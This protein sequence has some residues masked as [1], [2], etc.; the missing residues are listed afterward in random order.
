VGWWLAL[1]VAC[2]LRGPSLRRGHRANLRSRSGRGTGGL[3]TRGHGSSTTVR[4]SER[5]LGHDQ[6]QDLVL[7]I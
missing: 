1:A 7:P 5:G 6:T 4:N 2:V 3:E